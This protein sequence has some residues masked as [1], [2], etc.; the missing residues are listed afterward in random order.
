MSTYTYTSKA[1]AAYA[2]IREQILDGTLPAGSRL[3]QYELADD[4]GISITPLREAVRRLNGE[5]WIRL[6]SHKNARVAGLDLAEARD[7]LEVR[8]ALEPRAAELAASRR[9]DADITE[10]RASVAALVPV[11]RDWGEDALTRHSRFHR[12]LYAASHNAV[13]IKNL[14][15]LWARSDRYRRHGLSLP[16]GAEPRTR[17]LDDHRKIA[18]AVIDG[19]GERA[20]ALVEA[21]IANS[22]SA[23]ALLTAQGLPQVE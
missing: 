1:D 14:D 9:D 21:H 4:M 3:N 19:D 11:T 13:L 16:P 5:G 22:L 8:Q 6:D 7:L 18:D 12:A 17:D 23:A 10:L 15:D 20:R 2:R